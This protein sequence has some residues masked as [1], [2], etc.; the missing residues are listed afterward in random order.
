M[1][2]DL[3]RIKRIDCGKW[4]FLSATGWR[5]LM[6]ASKY[7]LPLENT[8]WDLV[9]AGVTTVFNWDYDNARDKLLALYEKGKT[10]QWNAN[11]RLDWSIEVDPLNPMGFPD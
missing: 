11:D 10:K 5:S 8:Q 2:L 9:G 6:S 7:T 3:T 4:I 1:A